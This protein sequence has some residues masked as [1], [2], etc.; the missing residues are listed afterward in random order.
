MPKKV[1]NIVKKSNSKKHVKKTAKS[2]L[3]AM[4]KIEDPRTRHFEYPITEILFIAVFAVMCGSESYQDFS[5]FG[6]SQLKWLK[7][8]LPL[9]NGVPSHDTFQ[10][11]FQL[12][13]PNSLEDVF[14]EVVASLKVSK[15]KHVAIDGKVSRGC[16]NI[17]GRSLLNIV[18]AWDTENGF[19]L[20]QVATKNE[21]GKDVGEFNAIPKLIELIDIKETLVTIDAGGCYAEITDSI[22][23][24]GG[25]YAITLKENQ[26]TLYRTAERLYEEAVQDDT[27]EIATH[28]ETNKGHGRIEERTYQAI[29]LPET[30][31]IDVKWNGIKTMVKSESTTVIGTVRSCYTRY[32]ICSLP[33]TEIVRISRG[34]RSHWGIENGL[35]WVLDV[36]FG[37]DAN[38]TRKGHG[39]ENLSKLRRIAVSLLN[40]VKG[41]KTIPN[42]MFQAALDANFRTE[43][44]NAAIT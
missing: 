42:V 34:I 3:L 7:Q 10:R 21:E 28:T 37:E 40:R 29:S 26:P 33:A 38:R 41:K 23:K 1:V 6:N 31:Q 30:E 39:A 44:L 18:S 32:Y 27:I 4:N 16:F 9:K 2:L 19:A 14:R 24:N 36:S 5:T 22:I 35:H 11:I 8:F 25:D 20:G 17:K 13:K 15:G 43:V 12:L